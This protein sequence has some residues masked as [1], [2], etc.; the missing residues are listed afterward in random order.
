M[1]VLC[2]DVFC[3]ACLDLINMA[4]LPTVGIGL[5]ADNTTDIIPFNYTMSGKTEMVYSQRNAIYNNED[6]P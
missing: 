6:S 3:L 4:V 1:L 5:D 2:F